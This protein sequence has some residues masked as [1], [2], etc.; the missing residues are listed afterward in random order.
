MAVGYSMWQPDQPWLSTARIGML[1][2]LSPIIIAGAFLSFLVIA[3]TWP[4]RK[5]FPPRPLTAAEMVEELDDMIGE[6]TDYEID[7]GLQV[8]TRCVFADER[9]EQLKLRVLALGIP[10]RTP[11]AVDELKLIRESARAIAAGD[12]V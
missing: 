5:L 11:A 7:Y 9:L 2:A 3:V 6:Q 10:P 8:I 1:I 4:V 12:A